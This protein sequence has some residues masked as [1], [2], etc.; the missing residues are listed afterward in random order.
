[1][2]NS[3]VWHLMFDI[4]PQYIGLIIA[5]VVAGGAIYCVQQWVTRYRGN[6]GWPIVD[7]RIDSYGESLRMPGAGGD[8]YRAVVYSY[9][10]KHGFYTGTWSSPFFRSEAA[11]IEFLENVLPIGSKAMVRYNP[12]HAEISLLHNPP[13]APHSDDLVNLNLNG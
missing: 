9:T 5:L 13:S 7:G 8:W 11:L 10:T 2:H 6:S 4:L 3:P 1:M 12:D